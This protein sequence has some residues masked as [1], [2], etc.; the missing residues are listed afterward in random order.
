MRVS[1]SSIKGIPVQKL[2]VFHGNGSQLQL[3]KIPC[4]LGR[5][6]GGGKEVTKEHV[7]F[8][9]LLM[10]VFRHNAY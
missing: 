10:E 1:I 2:V 5:E 6:W 7:A 3:I 4:W 9:P 8:Y